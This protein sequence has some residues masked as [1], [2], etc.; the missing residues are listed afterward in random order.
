MSRFLTPSKI[1]L[2]ALIE[3]YTY[4]IVPSSATIPVLSFIVNQLIPSLPSPRANRSL[5]PLPL[6]LDLKSFEAVLATHPSA[7]GV[8]GRTLWDYF[9]RK[10]WEM[11][12]LDALHSF[13]AGR[14]NLLAPTRE[15]IKKDGEIG[16][17][18]P[19]GDMI[20]LSRTSPFGSFVR[21]SRV[22]FE[23]LMF[24]D[25][26]S[27]WTAFVVWRQETRGYWARRNGPLHRWAGDKALSEGEKEWGNEATEMLETVAYGQLSLGEGQGGLAST[28]DVEKLLEFQVEQMQSR[29]PVCLLTYA[30]TNDPELGN[31]IPTEVKER[32]KSALDHSVKIPSLSHY[33]K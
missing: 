33:L 22:E 14:S 19:S 24:S 28:D 32:F 5:Q 4:A 15:D 13:F 3:L 10:L 31:R 7:S 26:V 12:S 21:R 27:L 29:L 20:M 23:R 1:G 11:D 6:V 8:P 25:A 16:I 9:L 2:L 17:S 30:V 18:P